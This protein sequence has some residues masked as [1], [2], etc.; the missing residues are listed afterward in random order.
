MAAYTV[1]YAGKL[2]GKAIGLPYVLS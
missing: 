1:S 2:T